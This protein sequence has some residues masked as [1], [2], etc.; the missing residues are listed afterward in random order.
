M[1]HSVTC[2]VEE[3][4]K[5]GLSQNTVNYGWP[6][7]LTLGS[8]NGDVIFFFKAVSQLRAFAESLITEMERM[9]DQQK[10]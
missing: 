3:D 5:I 6:F 1:I 9:Y 8:K 10:T 7:Y 4:L 2:F